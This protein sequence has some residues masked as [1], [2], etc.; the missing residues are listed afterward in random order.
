MQKLILA[1]LAFFMSIG[2]AFAAVD[3][4][5]ADQTAIDGLKGIGPVKAKAIV[6]ERKKNG[7]FKNIDDVQAR[8][9]GIG[10]ATVAA[11]KKDGSA[12]IGGS[13]AAA[14]AAKADAKPAKADA[15]AA[16]SDT[17]K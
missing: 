5:T 15:K 13:G 14:P 6:D 1:F 16:K 10:P 2:M 17:K 4:N 12:V 11:W 7:P 3:L 9:K 8:V